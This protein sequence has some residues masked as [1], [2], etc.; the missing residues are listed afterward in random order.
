MK[1]KIEIEVP[2]DKYCEGC[3]FLNEYEYGSNSVTEYECWL[4]N[5]ESLKGG[6]RKD[7]GKYIIANGKVIGSVAFKCKKCLELKSLDK[8]AG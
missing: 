8:K 3:S 2:D 7:K 6:Y 1:A 4:F 5:R